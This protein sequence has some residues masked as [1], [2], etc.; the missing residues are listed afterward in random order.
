MKKIVISEFMDTNAV[1]S[2]EDKFQV[3][4][5]KTL[6]DKQEELLSLLQDCDALIVRNK[7]QVR[8]ALLDAAP[9][10][11]AVGRLGV[12]LDNIDVAACKA[13]GIAVIPATGANSVSVA[14]YVMAG[15]L[16]LARGCYQRCS[17]VAAGQWPRA[18]MQGGEIF[19][20]TLGLLGFGGIARD[21][22]RRAQAFDMKVIA[23]DPFIAADAPL[24]QDHKVTPV[25]FEDMLAQ[26]DAISLH[27]PLTDSTRNLFNAERIASMKNG[28]FLIN[29]SR[30]GIVDEAALG[31]A[32]RS[33][34]MGGAMIDVFAREPLPAGSPLA[35]APNCLLTPHIAGVTKESNTRVSAMIAEKV[36]AAL[37][38]N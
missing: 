13:R 12:G 7:T 1:K 22:A 20:K 35:D 3:T 34:K 14:E 18:T 11:R 33:G 31:E 25:S 8:G 28:A 30:G 10:L 2:L 32:L 23:Y 6:V 24:W 36:A 4:Y 15:L 5:D 9:N 37:A 16:M 21:V 29:S 26:S 27:V 19:G 38:E 17:E